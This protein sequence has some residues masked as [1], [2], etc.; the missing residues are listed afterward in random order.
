[1]P[2]PNTKQKGILIA[3]A[4]IIGAMLLFPPFYA[5]R[6]VGGSTS[7]TW[8]FTADTEGRVDVGLLFTQFFV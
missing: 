1:M 2:N 8:L 5:E 7:Y 6:R 4:I 3:V